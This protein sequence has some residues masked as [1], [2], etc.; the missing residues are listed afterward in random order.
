MTTKKVTKKKATKIVAK[1]KSAKKK[2]ASK[3]T[4]KKVTKKV[5]KKSSTKTT[6]KKKPTVK[7]VGVKKKVTKKKVINLDACID[8]YDMTSENKMVKKEV[9]KEVNTEKNKPSKAH[10]EFQKKMLAKMG[11]YDSDTVDDGVTNE[12]GHWDGSTIS[13]DKIN[14][15]TD[16]HEKRLVIDLD[17]VQE[18]IRVLREERDPDNAY[19]LSELMIKQ[20]EI[21]H[22][23]N[24][25][26]PA[27]YI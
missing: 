4:T 25:I 24:E 26:N 12:N 8:N 9:V 23:L 20:N 22:E 13:D 21:R 2:V 1:K 5:A 14:A 27:K 16:P 17:K 19:R 7:K 10:E 15:I 6:A 3:K 11:K 18:E